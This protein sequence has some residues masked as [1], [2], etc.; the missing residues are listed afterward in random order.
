MPRSRCPASRRPA[1]LHRSTPGARWGGECCRT[2]HPAP[3][4]GGSLP[5][6]TPLA[7]A[8]GYLG[9]LQ[10]PP[11]R[12]EVE[13][14]AI[15]GALQRGP[16]DDEDED[17]QVGEGGCEVQH[18]HKGMAWLGSAPLR[19]RGPPLPP[20]HIAPHLARTADALQHAEEDEDPGHHQAK[21]KGPLHRAR[22]PKAG[23]VGHPQH[24]LSAVWGCGSVRQEGPSSPPQCPRL[25]LH[26]ASGITDCCPQRLSL[27]P[28]GPGET[29]L[30]PS[31]Q[32]RAEGGTHQCCHAG[33][34]FQN[35]S[36]ALSWLA[37]PK[38]FC[39]TQ[40]WQV[41]II[42]TIP[43]VPPGPSPSVTLLSCCRKSFTQEK[44]PAQSLCGV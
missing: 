12:G 4:E 26:K 29:E 28:S 40:P 5:P 42:V 43:Y 36:L 25:P 9:A 14:D 8:R 34:Y 11:V 19:R 23:A 15:E 32:T 18:L 17:D 20:P 31:P 35:T 3:A 44:L 39:N 24:P 6:G 13:A 22:V 41:T 1:T 33:T 38:A 27:G 7:P 2:P 16:V 21:G 10:P 30:G 37:F